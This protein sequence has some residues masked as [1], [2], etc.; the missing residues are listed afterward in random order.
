MK[1][2]DDRFFKAAQKLAETRSTCLKIQTGAVVVKNGKVVGKGFNLCSPEGFNHGQKIKECKRMN[3]PS[4]VGYELC[5]PLHAEVAA[6]VDAGPKRSKGATLY[7]SGHYYPCW[8]CEGQARLAGIVEIKVRDKE[9]LI[10][11]KSNKI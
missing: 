11:Y 6:V 3:L 5:K 7:L 4:G 10:F 9:A 1:R 2:N 8:N